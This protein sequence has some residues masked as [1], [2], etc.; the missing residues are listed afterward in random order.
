M[1]ATLLAREAVKRSK[2]REIIFKRD[3]EK[4]RDWAAILAKIITENN[5]E[6]YLFKHGL[7]K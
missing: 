7:Y 1:E 6:E 3:E 5:V 4:S 2:G